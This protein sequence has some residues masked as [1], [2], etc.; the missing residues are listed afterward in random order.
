MADNNL[1]LDFAAL[2]LRVMRECP[3]QPGLL[4]LLWPHSLTCDRFPMPKRGRQQLPPAS[5]MRPLSGDRV[6]RVEKH[7]LDLILRGEKTAEVRRGK[8][9]PGG[10]WL[11]YKGRVYA[12]MELG[13][14]RQICTLADFAA[15]EPWHRVLSAQ[16]L[17]YGDHTHL[18]PLLCVS[19]EDG[20]GHLASFRGP[21]RHCCTSRCPRGRGGA[22]VRALETSSVARWRSACRSV[23]R[24]CDGVSCSLLL[25]SGAAVT[26]EAREVWL[27]EP[28]CLL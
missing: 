22:G 20:P 3:L 21:P 24:A 12:W 9:A 26:S 18:W 17:P 23:S 7:W 16:R 15:A 6:L 28:R 5:Q 27:S 1:V 10:C 8:V 4:R 13:S 2:F 25:W 11:G 14:A 19:G